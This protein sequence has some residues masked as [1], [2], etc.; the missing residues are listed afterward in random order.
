MVAYCDASLDG[1]GVYFPAAGLGYQSKPPASA[2]DDLI[3]YLEAFCVA[4]AL[5]LIP[6][7]VRAR[8]SVVCTITIWTDNQNTYNIFN[9]LRAKPLYNEILKYAVDILLDNDFKLCVLLLPGKKNVVA[10]ALSR[11]RNGTAVSAHPGLL[12]DGSKPLPLIPYT[13]PRVALGAAKK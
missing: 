5:Q 2:P 8:G 11:W 13:P 12:I 10:D 9:T 6:D 3:F 4:W 7:L 1:L